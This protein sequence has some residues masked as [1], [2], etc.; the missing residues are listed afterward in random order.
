[1]TKSIYYIRSANQTTTKNGNLKALKGALNNSKEK[2]PE[3]FVQ[4]H[5]IMMSTFFLRPSPPEECHLYFT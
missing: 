2:K 5:K 3:Y 4:H 1:M